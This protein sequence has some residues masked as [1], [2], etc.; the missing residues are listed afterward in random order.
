MDEDIQE[1]C[2]KVSLGHE[3]K[4]KLVPFVTPRLKQIL[5]FIGL[6]LR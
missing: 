3:F 1:Y 2:W 6:S 4:E 5:G